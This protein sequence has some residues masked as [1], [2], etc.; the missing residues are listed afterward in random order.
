MTRSAIA[1]LAV[2]AACSSDK[3]PAPTPASAD[4]EPER[5]RG[6]ALIGELKKSLVG[7]LT[8]A[9]ADGIPNAIEVCNIEAPRLAAALATDGAKLGR[10]TRKPRNPSNA[11]TGWQAEAL[12]YFEGIKAAGKPL[13]GTSF[14]RRLDDGRFG[15]A[16][17]LIIQELCVACHGATL[18]PEVTAALASRYPT[19]QA[20]GYAVGDLRGVAWA[21]LP[22]ARR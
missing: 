2:L 19:D 5:A 11:A 18:A 6:A 10:A 21:E 4:S 22:A 16:E 3:A 1:V 13:A 12:S 15:Y 14:G 8:K 20:T 9:M 17:P 7:A